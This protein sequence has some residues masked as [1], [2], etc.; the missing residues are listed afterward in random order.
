MM[1][2]KVVPKSQVLQV[3]PVQP[4]T[5]IQ[6]VLQVLP[7]PALQQVP[8]VQPCTRIQILLASAYGPGLTLLR[9]PTPDGI[10]WS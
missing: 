9:A 4:C 2:E 8:P 1:E 6:P 7:V 3:L 5:R 10:I